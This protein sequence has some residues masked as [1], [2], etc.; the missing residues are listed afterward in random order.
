V[1]SE[2]SDDRGKSLY[3][4]LAA[5]FAIPIGPDISDDYSMRGG[6]TLHFTGA[7]FATDWMVGGMLR[8]W[9]AL[10]GGAVSD[11]IVSG[12]V[13]YADDR[14]RSLESSLYYFVVGPFADVYFSPPAGWHVQALLGVAR[15]A[16]ADDLNSGATGFGA[17]VGVGYE[18]AVAERWN[19]GGLARLAIS[20]LSMGATGGEKP[21]PAV[22][23][24]GLLF[25]ATFRPAR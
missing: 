24:P 14:K 16:R 5:G 15:I 18:V 17:V 10:G 23:E 9:L 7:S 19:V 13:R 22:F 25:T 12:S 6:R 4:R 2:P 11:T 8:P 21:S 1:E 20:P 3:I